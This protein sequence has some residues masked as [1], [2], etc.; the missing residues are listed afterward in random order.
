MP[1]P[2][3][4]SEPTETI[5]RFVLA[6]DHVPGGMI[7]SG[8][9]LLQTTVSGSLQPWCPGRIRKANDAAGVWQCRPIWELSPLGKKQSERPV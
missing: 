2:T 7:S 6:K 1:S 4:L 9:K 3:L 8:R 5:I